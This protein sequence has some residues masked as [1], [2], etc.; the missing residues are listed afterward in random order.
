[1]KKTAAI[2]L[3]LLSLIA[4][5]NEYYDI[6]L[7][8]DE[9]QETGG[10]KVNLEITRSDIINSKASV[11]TLFSNNDV[12]FIF[13]KGITAPKYLEMKYNSSRM[14]WTP[15]AK[16]E[17]SVSDLNN[18]VNKKMTAI[19]LP[20]GSGATIVADDG[21]FLFQDDL[22][23]PLNY[24]GYY[25]QVELADY[26]IDEGTLSGSLPLSGPS[27][28]SAEDRLIHFDIS[29][30][31]SGNKYDLYQEYVKPLLFRGVSSDGII[32]STVLSAG[33]AITGYQDGSMM[34][35][36]GIL[37][38]RAVGSAV[39]Y[40]FSI[41]DW[42]DYILYTRDANTKIV[43]DNKY[44]GIG[45]ISTS[46]WTKDIHGGYIDLGLSVKWAPYNVGASSPEG[47]GDLYEWGEIETRSLSPSGYGIKYLYSAQY[48]SYWSNG[49][50]LSKYNNNSEIGIVDNKTTLEPEDDVAHIKWG[51]EWRMP[52]KTEFDE[53]YAN[54][55]SAWTTQ[56]AI[57]GCMMNSRKL[58][59]E[60]R[61]VFLS[62]AG[63]AN[64]EGCRRGG[65]CWYWTSSL[66][67]A[68]PSSAWMFEFDSSTESYRNAN[69]TTGCPRSDGLSVRPVCP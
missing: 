57:N 60:D 2:L 29:G 51:G 61:Y 26:S 25:L 58:G 21:S 31:T 16:N 15:T 19:Y 9:K 44:I 64:N 34:S 46:T 62:G 7:H 1:M 48:N 23:N 40:S 39:D 18:A 56:N 17:L 35:F 24:K 38:A 11:K 27:L 52:T 13:F 32:S 6:N 50:N 63:R 55:I 45:D 68:Y 65:A 4:C 41:N 36:S 3:G 22:G 42:T 20:Y 10:I 33:A 47:Y 66:Y 67:T 59:Y 49:T 43:S 12:V 69:I 28:A 37:D 14:D 53:L 54:C 30:F 8:A 5:N